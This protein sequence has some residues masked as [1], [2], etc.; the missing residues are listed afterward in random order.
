MVCLFE[1]SL[2]NL[3]NISQIL[4]N[5]REK[6]AANAAFPEEQSIQRIFVINGLLL[7]LAERLQ[8]DDL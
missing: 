6:F 5:L 4:A 1:S 8:T 2:A 3:D 7:E